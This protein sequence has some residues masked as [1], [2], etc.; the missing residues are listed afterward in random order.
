MDNKD[1]PYIKHAY[2]M[3]F[4]F[5]KNGAN[6][7]NCH[8]GLFTTKKMTKAW[9]EGKADGEKQKATD[10]AINASS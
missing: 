3:G 1:A 10:E 9:E 4:D 5:G 8:F 2:E 6:A 7:T